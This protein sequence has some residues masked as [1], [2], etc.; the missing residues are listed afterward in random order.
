[1]K[2]KPLTFLLALTFL[3]LFS[4]SVYGG[5]LDETLDGVFDRKDGVVV[6]LCV[7][8]GPSVFFTVNMKEKVIKEYPGTDAYYTYKINKKNEVYILG[9]RTLLKGSREKDRV[10]VRITRHKY[11]NII[12]LRLDNLDI[13]GPSK[14]NPINYECVV[15]EKEF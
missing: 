9:L 2:T 4:G 7:G 10:S 1:M 3:F 13:K 11:Q 8:R 14:R 15:G 5:V 6:L 12:R